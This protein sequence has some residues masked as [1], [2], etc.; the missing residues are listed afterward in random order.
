LNRNYS[1]KLY[2]ST[3]ASIRTGSDYNLAGILLQYRW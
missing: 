3:G 2:G 1:I